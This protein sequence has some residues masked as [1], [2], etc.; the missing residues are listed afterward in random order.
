MAVVVP[1]IETASHPKIQS[2]TADD[3]AG[4]D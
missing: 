2:L 4:I 1:Y 3:F